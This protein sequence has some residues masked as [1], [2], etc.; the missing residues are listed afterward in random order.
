MRTAA[1]LHDQQAVAML[2]PD[3]D[4]SCE[5]RLQL[6]TDLVDTVRS[7]L[8]GYGISRHPIT[9][10]FADCAGP[11]A[12]GPQAKR[13]DRPGLRCRTLNDVTTGR[14]VRKPGYR[15]EAQPVGGQKGGGSTGACV[16]GLNTLL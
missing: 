2:V 6:I 7:S 3:A 16:F 15:E 10:S 1:S 11:I 4:L 12:S 13:C 5:I 9:D 8:D 14:R